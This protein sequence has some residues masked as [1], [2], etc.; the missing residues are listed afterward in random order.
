MSL[1]PHLSSFWWTMMMLL[2]LFQPHQA[3]QMFDPDWE[4]LVIERQPVRTLGRLLTSA[5]ALEFVRLFDR[6]L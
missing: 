4:L 6:L 1:Q 3:D 2:H 5:Q